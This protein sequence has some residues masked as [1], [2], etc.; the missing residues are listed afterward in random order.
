MNPSDRRAKLT[1]HLYDTGI[2]FDLKA[3]NDFTFIRDI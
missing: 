1:N 3:D 2:L